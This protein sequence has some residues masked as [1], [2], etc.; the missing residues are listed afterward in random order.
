[1]LYD[2]KNTVENSIYKDFKNKTSNGK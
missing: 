2:G 1:M